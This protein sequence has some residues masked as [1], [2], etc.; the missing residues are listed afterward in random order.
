MAVDVTK[1]FSSN[2]QKKKKKKIPHAVDSLFKL[3]K[4]KQTREKNPETNKKKNNR[5]LLNNTRAHN[6][7]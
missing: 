5:I 7:Q 1:V 3:K 4:N 6:L 2:K